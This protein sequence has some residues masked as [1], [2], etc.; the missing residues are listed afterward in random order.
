MSAEHGERVE[1]VTLSDA[2]AFIVGQ[3]GYDF[4]RRTF[5]RWC[6]AGCV[7]VDATTHEITA[8]KVGGLWYIERHSLSQ[9]IAFLN[10]KNCG[11]WLVCG[12][13]TAGL[14]GA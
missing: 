9:L 7:E 14:N 5:L 6:E 11:F 4:D 2:I 8:H 12:W 1:R 3:T 10:G 13:F